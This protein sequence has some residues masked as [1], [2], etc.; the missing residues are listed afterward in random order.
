MANVLVVVSGHFSPFPHVGHLAYLKAAKAWG[1]Y[2]YV[3][4]NSDVQL[5][6]KGRP[7]IVNEQER[8]TQVEAVRWVDGVILSRDEDLSVC[9]TLRYLVGRNERI[10]FAN[11]GDVGRENCREKEVCDELGIAMVFGVGGVEKIQSSSAILGKMKNSF[12]DSPL[13]K[14]P[15]G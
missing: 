1:D 14:R 3:I 12:P 15:P 8:A 13:P 7:V 4:V 5:L 10:I 6:L 9:E 2:L 11:G